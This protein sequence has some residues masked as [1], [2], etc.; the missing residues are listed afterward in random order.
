MDYEVFWFKQP[1]HLFRWDNYTFIIPNGAMTLDQKLNA[2]V[3]FSIYFSVLLVFLRKSLNPLILPCIIGAVTIMIHNAHKT[4]PTEVFDNLTKKP[5]TRPTKDNP[6]MNIM[7]DEY[8]SNPNRPGACDVESRVVRN[9]MKQM[10]E[11]GLYRDVDD[12]FSKQASDR[13]Y[14]TMPITT[15]PNDQSGFV[16]WLYGTT[17]HIRDTYELGK[18][19]ETF[20]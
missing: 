16:N 19:S 14:Y 12:V 10:F 8:E 17:G 4:K 7:L 18:P 11:E 20:F 3:R 15:I 13:Q 5:C 6:F 2:I 9:K 1:Q